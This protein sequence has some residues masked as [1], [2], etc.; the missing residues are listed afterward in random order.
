MKAIS[1]NE[2][3]A[4]MQRHIKVSVYVPLCV[5]LFLCQSLSLSLPHSFLPFIILYN[6]FLYFPFLYSL[7]LCLSPPWLSPSF[8]LWPFH[9]FPSPLILL[10]IFSSCSIPPPLASS[11]I[12]TNSSVSTF[13]FSLFLPL[14]L[15]PL[16]SFSHSSTIV[17]SSAV[18]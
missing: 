11:I 4:F 6:L 15:L 7:T 3:P 12:F 5:C 9:S 17:A 8:S 10:L 14:C 1:M 16:F 13:F 18:H 2:V